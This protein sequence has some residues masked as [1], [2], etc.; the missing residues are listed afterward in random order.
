MPAR[1]AFATETASFL[2]SL[3]RLGFCFGAPVGD[4]LVGE[5]PS[6]GQVGEHAAH[7][8]GGFPPALHLGSG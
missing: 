8:F 4:Q 3:S 2:G 5:F 6:R 7:S 1:P